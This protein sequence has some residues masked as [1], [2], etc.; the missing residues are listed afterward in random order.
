MQLKT[1]ISFIDHMIRPFRKYTN[2]QKKFDPDFFKDN[3]KKSNE[4]RRHVLSNSVTTMYFPGCFFTNN[5]N[6]NQ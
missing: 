6:K 4:Y 1:C 3:T 2:A 5:D